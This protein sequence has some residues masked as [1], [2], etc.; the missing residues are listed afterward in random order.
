MRRAELAGL[1]VGEIDLDHNVAVVLG[2]GSRPRA[3][4]FGKRTAV[5]LDR[6]LRVRAKH[7]GSDRGELWLGRLGQMTANGLYQV[8]QSRAEQAG[9]GKIHTH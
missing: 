6:Y 9:L 3:C 8:L 2:K 4:P 7:R 1:R 5:A